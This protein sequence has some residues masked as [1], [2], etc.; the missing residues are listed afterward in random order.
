MLGTNIKIQWFRGLISNYR[1]FMGQIYM[2][3]KKT[4]FQMVDVDIIFLLK[5]HTKI[6]WFMIRTWVVRLNW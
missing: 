6:L 3:K 2:E 5:V 4:Y 1:F